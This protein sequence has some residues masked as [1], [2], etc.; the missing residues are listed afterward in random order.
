MKTRLLVAMTGLLAIGLA[1]P[2]AAQR[3]TTCD[4][5][6]D[7]C[8]QIIR[9]FEQF[10][11]ASAI[12]TLRALSWGLARTPFLLGKGRC[13]PAKRRSGRTTVT[14][15]RLDLLTTLAQS[16]K[17]MLLITL[18]G[19]WGHIVSPGRVRTIPL[20]TTTAIGERFM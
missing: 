20:R 13:F 1:V 12:K 3:P 17:Y 14:A 7:A 15:L 19:P 2:T 18:R 5:P 10:V 6:Q 8:Q 11:T 16:I 9:S 4:G